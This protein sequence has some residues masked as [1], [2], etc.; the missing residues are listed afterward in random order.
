MAVESPR[1]EAIRSNKPSREE[2]RRQ[3]LQEYI[4]DLR[5]V[6]RKNAR[7]VELR[8]PSKIARRIQ[9]AEHCRLANEGVKDCHRAPAL[10]KLGT[11][12]SWSLPP[13]EA[14]AHIRAGSSNGGFWFRKVEKY[15]IFQ[16]D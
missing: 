4:D 12:L 1:N 2:E 7:K 13:A 5:A 9:N 3:V 11:E 8:P 15:T 6:I 16:G 14:S 10:G